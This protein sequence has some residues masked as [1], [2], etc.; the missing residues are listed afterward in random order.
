MAETG[1]TVR[2]ARSCTQPADHKP[3][4][5]RTP[6]YQA[7]VWDRRERKRIRKTFATVAA[8]KTWRQ[9]ALPALRK[10]TMRATTQITLR[11]A[12]EVWEGGARDA[13]IRTRSG[14]EYKPSALR[15]YSAS[16]RLYVLD[17][18]GALK[19]SEVSRLQL[20]DL[21]DRMLADGKDPST[22][23]NTLM[24]LRALF[25]RAVER[26]D[27]AVNPTTGIRLAASRGRRD[28]IAS[29]T[30]A[31][32]LIAAVA[33]ADRAVW[34]T[35]YYAGLRLGELRALRDEDVDLQAGV[36]RVERSWDRVEGVIETKT[37]AGR[38]K[39]PIVAALRTHLAARKLRR[40]SAAGLFFGDGDRPFNRDQLVARAERA[41]K[42]AA[43]API[44][45]HEGRHTCASIL[46][47]AGVNVKALSS[48]LGHSSITITLDRYGHLMPGSED[49]A[50]ERVD[51]Y[52]ERA[53]EE[54]R[55]S[56]RG[57]G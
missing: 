29:P 41:W 8:A 39:V 51:A 26:G 23:R 31:A 53:V 2:H 5:R 4:A 18:L 14:D 43:L 1:I 21:A 57:T 38:R 16:M 9:D 47:A 49:E 27:V 55:L 50:V 30:E 44:G 24:P 28:R 6:T 48:Y 10:G 40:G 32:A 15:G 13:T 46:I 25:R 56:G 35:A 34:A 3:N 45:L 37:R 33:D 54:S 22:I 19:L 12:W 42:A 11:A 17:D 20:Q 52:L 7:H 36:I